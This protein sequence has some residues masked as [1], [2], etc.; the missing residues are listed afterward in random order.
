MTSPPLL[1]FNSLTAVLCY[2]S[3]REAASPA[4]ETNK[5]QSP[6][7]PESPGK[8]ATPVISQQQIHAHKTGQRRLSAVPFSF[9][10]SIYEGKR[11][12]Q[13][14]FFILHHY[15]FFLDFAGN[16]TLLFP[17]PLTLPAICLSLS[18]SLSFAA[19]GRFYALPSVYP[20][21]QRST[22]PPQIPRTAVARPPRSLA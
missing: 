16:A 7:K 22:R 1:P 5:K 9:P 13:H 2:D 10:A 8:P 17:H 20:P 21:L 12:Q 3:L 14:F 18:L 4:A 15:P 11:T 19:R 6:R